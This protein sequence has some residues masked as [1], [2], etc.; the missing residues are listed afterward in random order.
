LLSVGIDIGGT[1]TKAGVVDEAGLVVG[2]LTAP[3]P[4]LSARAAEDSIVGL[5]EQLSEAW[6]VGAVGVGAAGWVDRDL[7]SVR[8]SP[9]LAWRDE[10]L[11]ARLA[12]RLPLPVL[13]DNDANAA[14]WAEYSF[15]AGAGAR[16]LV[17][18]TLGTGIGGALVVEGKV[19]RGAFGLAG[20]WGHTAVVPQGHWCPCGNR[21][22]W[23]QYASANAL[24]REARQLVATGSPQAAAL[25][26]LNESGGLTGAAVTALARQG[27][28]A[29]AELIGEMGTWLG[30][31]LANVAAGLDPDVFVVGGG[32]S[33]A[34]GLLLDPARAAYARSLTGRGFRP[35]A[36]IRPARLGN[37][38]GLVGAADL[39]RQAALASA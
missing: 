21:G 28:Q 37:D 30:L 29:S 36:D 19:F 23:E 12:D 32:L 13:V 35:L 20:E 1:D 34:G 5:V 9:H 24:L 22:C 26:A 39:A 18:I 3:S 7:A 8:F 15:G 16:I 10:P 2:R 4:S 31:G 25:A 38:A 17:L 33:R 11:A 27:D 6:P 14:A